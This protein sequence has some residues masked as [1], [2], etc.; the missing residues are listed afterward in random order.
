MLY[1]RTTRDAPVGSQTLHMTP[2]S[3]RTVHDVAGLDAVSAYFL[4]RYA[5]LQAIH[6]L[7]VAI[8]NLERTTSVTIATRW[9][10]CDE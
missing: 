6:D 10:D 3:I 1:E 2:V 9:E 4:A 5:H 8:A 7:D